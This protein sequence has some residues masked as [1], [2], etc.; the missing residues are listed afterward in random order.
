MIVR[1]TPHRGCPRVV[2]ATPD[3]ELAR[4]VY[5]LRCR[6]ARAGTRTELATDDGAVVAADVS[7]R[8]QAFH[9]AG[10]APRQPLLF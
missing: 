8:A 3:E 9:V 2:L 10:R 6:A 1:Q 7:E 5:A 4:I